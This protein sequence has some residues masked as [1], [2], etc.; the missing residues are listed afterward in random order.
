MVTKLGHG[1]GRCSPQHRLF[2]LAKASTQSTADLFH[3]RVKFTRIHCVL[4]D[5]KRGD[6]FCHVSNFDGIGSFCDAKVF[7]TIPKCQGQLA[8]WRSKPPLLHALGHFDLL[9]LA[10]F[11]ID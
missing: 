1:L 5:A 7:G 6:E 10:G 2:L 9:S 8:V 3:L 11:R 4:D